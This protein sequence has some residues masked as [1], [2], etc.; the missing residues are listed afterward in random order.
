[1]RAFSSVAQA[2]RHRAVPL[3]AAGSPALN[4]VQR[5]STALVGKSSCAA[6]VR[7]MRL[8]STKFFSTGIPSP[9]A[10]VAH[11]LVKDGTARFND[12]ELDQA[13]QCFRQSLL[14]LQDM[15]ATEVDNNSQLLESAS[16]VNL[17]NVLRERYRVSSD[18]ATGKEVVII[19]DAALESVKRVFGEGHIRVA[20][21][22]RE[23]A[24]H[25]ELVGDQ[26]PA[27][28]E[29]LRQALAIRSHWSTVTA[30]ATESDAG[31][32]AS[33]SAD[34]AE[35]I[36]M[37]VSLARACQAQGK[38]AEV[39]EL[40]TPLMDCLGVLEAHAQ[41]QPGA[42]VVNKKGAEIFVSALKHVREY[43]LVSGQSSASVD[44]M[45]DMF[46]Q[47]MVGLDGLTTAEPGMTE[48]EARASATGNVQGV[49]WR[50]M[51]NGASKTAAKG[52]RPTKTG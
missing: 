43:K 10:A 1:M 37:I 15:C 35:R 50:Q 27:V 32:L 23:K 13:E 17:A 24:I 16:L 19:F 38:N 14:V 52:K 5:F 6:L 29:S 3:L 4:S 51:K 34:A 44:Q 9:P 8:P 25:L 36:A 45:L 48:A 7:M 28:E 30:P 12:G 40:D 49:Y 31:S 20:K 39:A 26:W 18:R 22:L 47:A 41:P 21:T 11:Q 46:Q 42:G 2:V 33:V